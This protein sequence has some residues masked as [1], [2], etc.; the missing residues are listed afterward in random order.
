[1][2]GKIG[3]IQAGV[4]DCIVKCRPVKRR[5][6]WKIAVRNVSATYIQNRIRI[7]TISQAPA[8]GTPYS[9]MQENMTARLRSHVGLSDTRHQ[10]ACSWRDEEVTHVHK[11]TLCRVMQSLP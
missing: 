4:M 7:V 1:M 8:E 10:S 2:I 9:W 6:Y 11:K 5:W 3:K